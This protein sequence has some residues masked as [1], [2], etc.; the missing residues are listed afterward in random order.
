LKPKVEAE[1]LAQ[2]VNALS[3]IIGRRS[4]LEGSSN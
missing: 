4:Q 2:F 3:T 1:R